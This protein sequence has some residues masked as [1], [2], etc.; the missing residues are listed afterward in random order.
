[1]KFKCPC[2]N[3]KTLGGKP[4]GTYDICPVCWWED[5]PVQFDDP[6]YEG[7]ANKVSLNQAKKNFVEFGAS[8]KQFLVRARKPKKEEQ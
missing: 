5:D 3:Y 8:E 4:P 2:C 6:N 1:M 7:G